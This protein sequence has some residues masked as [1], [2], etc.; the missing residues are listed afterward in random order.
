[1]SAPSPRPK[2]S[3][4]VFRVAI[5]AAVVTAAS[6][7]IGALEGGRDPHAVTRQ[8]FSGIPHPLRAAFYVAVVVGILVSGWLFAR[9]VENWQRGA[10]ERRPTMPANRGRRLGRSYV[11]WNS[12]SPA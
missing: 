9:R 11:V 3:Q 10:A 2:A 7:I 8:V 12:E 4:I 6:G 5:G 1:M